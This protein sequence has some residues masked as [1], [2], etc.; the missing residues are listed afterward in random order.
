[1]QRLKQLTARIRSFASGV[2]YFKYDSKIRLWEKLTFEQ[3][4]QEGEKFACEELS[5]RRKSRIKD[6]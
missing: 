6:G 1:M 5:S 2:S 4:L 3:R